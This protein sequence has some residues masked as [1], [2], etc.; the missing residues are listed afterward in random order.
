MERLKK[1]VR[2][3]KCLCHNKECKEI[4]ACPSFHEKCY[5]EL[6]IHTAICWDFAL[7]LENTLSLLP[8]I[9]KILKD[10]KIPSSPE[11]FYRSKMEQF[12]LEKTLYLVEF[13]SHTFSRHC[14][15]YPEI[16]SS[17]EMIKQDISI[18]KSLLF[19]KGRIGRMEI[20]EDIEMVYC[21][22]CFFFRWECNP[23]PEDYNK[24]CPSYVKD[25]KGEEKWGQQ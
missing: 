5:V 18:L 10:K 6:D 25:E 13:L 4:D 12:S 8:F 24:Y 15:R 11:N 17:L 14:Y 23:E 2:D 22:N 1:K 9:M 7:Q 16:L 21:P 20:K 3:L 19:Q